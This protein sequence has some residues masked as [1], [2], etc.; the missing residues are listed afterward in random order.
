MAKKKDR[1]QD[2]AGSA[3]EL[4]E[5]DRATAAAAADRRGTFITLA[6]PAGDVRFYSLQ[7]EQAVGFRRRLAELW[8][9]FSALVDQQEAELTGEQ[10]IE[11]AKLLQATARASQGRPKLIW[12]G[13][14]GRQLLASGFLEPGQLVS[15]AAAIAKFNALMA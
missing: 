14:H 1:D 8:P 10:R 13:Q 15:L 3:P 11:L 12:P 9:S 4:P 5:A 7:P 6:T 2:L